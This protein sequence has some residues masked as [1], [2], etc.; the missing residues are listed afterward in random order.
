MNSL[1][2]ISISAPMRHWDFHLMGSVQHLLYSQVLTLVVLLPIILVIIVLQHIVIVVHRPFAKPIF[3]FLFEGPP[4]CRR[5][6]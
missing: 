2:H 3:V 6:C 4:H 1:I 5:S